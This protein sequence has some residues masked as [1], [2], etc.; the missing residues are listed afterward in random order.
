M[1]M[2]RRRTQFR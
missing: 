2:P 1:M